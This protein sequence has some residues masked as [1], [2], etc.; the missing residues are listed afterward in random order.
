MLL[1]WGDVFLDGSGLFIFLATD[2]TRVKRGVQRDSGEG[3]KL[4]G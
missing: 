2:K 3:K 4:K 1:V